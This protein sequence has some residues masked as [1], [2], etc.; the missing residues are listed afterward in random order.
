M[1]FKEGIMPLKQVTKP[2]FTIDAPGYE[3]V[4][5]E[6]LPRRHPKAKDGLLTSPCE[7][8]ETLYDIIERG[9]RVYSNNNAMGRRKLI[10]MHSEK[11]KVQKLVDGEPTEVEK[12]WHLFELTGFDFMTYKEYYKY[13]T[14]IG[15]GLRALGLEPGNR[16][17]LFAATR[18]VCNPIPSP[19]PF[20]FTFL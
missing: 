2:P 18:C 12:E 10:K 8:V 15:A 6:T 5:G 14:D 11:K 3:R 7:G 16:L 17:H 4:D 20:F 13:C 1:S 19:P 9:N